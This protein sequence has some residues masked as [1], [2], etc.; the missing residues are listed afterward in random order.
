MSILNT[1]FFNEHMSHDWP[2]FKLRFPAELKTEL[3]NKA[4]INKRPLNSE[5]ISRLEESLSYEATNAKQNNDMAKKLEDLQRSFL[6]L[7][8]KAE[9]G[10]KKNE[11]FNKYLLPAVCSSKTVRLNS[12]GTTYGDK[13]QLMAFA[14]NFPKAK[15]V[16]FGIRD[17]HLN[18]SA[19]TVAIFDDEHTFVADSTPMTVERQPRENE[20]FDLLFMLDVRGLLDVAEFAVTRVK[21]TRN[22]PVDQA[23]EELEQYETKPVRSNIYEFLSLFFREPEQV[24]PDWFVDEWKKLN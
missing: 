12:T 7:A 22:L 9:R 20:V 2:Q 24:K 3:Q 21:Q 1:N 13:H 14:S 17:S 15:R 16:L 6:P 4:K 10:L 19:L 23:I 18:H 11:E 5:I 8:R